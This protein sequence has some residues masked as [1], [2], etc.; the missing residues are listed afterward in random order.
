MSDERRQDT[1]EEAPGAAEPAASGE[2][3]AGEAQALAGEA[4][5]RAASAGEGEPGVGGAAAASE[6]LL[7]A[8]EVVVEL[9]ARLGAEVDV[10]VRDSPDAIACNVRVRAGGQVFEV[11]PRGQVL[12]AVQILANRIVN[13]DAEGRKWIT[14][15]LGGFRQVQTEPAMQDMARRLGEAARRIGKTLTVLPMHS[16]DRRV[17]HQV[18]SEMQGVRTRSEGEG[19]LRRLLVEPAEAG[20]GEEA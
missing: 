7:R 20:G 18:I 8:R 14:V 5:E 3:G 1:L 6:K 12:E 19:L 16:R 2:A 11:G 4:D 9:C 15:E 13:R 17:V 10:E